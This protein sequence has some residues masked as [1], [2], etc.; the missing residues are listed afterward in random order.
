[1]RAAVE[2]AD[3]LEVEVRFFFFAGGDTD[4]EVLCL[5][6]PRPTPLP[7]LNLQLGGVQV[8]LLLF[9]F[10]GMRFESKLD[11]Q[12]S[13]FVATSFVN[14]VGVEVDFGDEVAKL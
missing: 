11:T 8:R 12:L 1:M 6:A 10:L 2:L 9:W 3:V 13:T 5:A 7:P 4:D 14:N